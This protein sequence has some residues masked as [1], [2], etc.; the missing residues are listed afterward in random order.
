MSRIPASD[1]ETARAFLSSYRCAERGIAMRLR[2]LE[3]L[4]ALGNQ[5]RTTVKPGMRSDSLG[6]IQA[7][8]KET[9]DAVSQLCIQRQ[10]VETAIAQVA[11]DTLREILERHYIQMQPFNQ[12]AR[13]LHYTDRHVSRLH[14]KALEYIRL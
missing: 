8:E 3:R 5:V 4:K 7:L 11:D 10:K 12:I 1:C 13:D 2:E 14:R 9:A 6:R